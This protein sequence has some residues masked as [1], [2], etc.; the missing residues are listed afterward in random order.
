MD[1]NKTYTE[2]MSEPKLCPKCGE[3]LQQCEG[4]ENMG[5]ADCDGY[6]VTHDGVVLCSECGAVCK[7]D[8]DAMRAVG[9]GSCALFSNEDIEGQGWCELHQES[10][11]YIDKCNDRLPKAVVK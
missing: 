4:C 6:I 9:C 11:Y 5:C 1:I 3:E 10:T 7:A 2:I 8:C